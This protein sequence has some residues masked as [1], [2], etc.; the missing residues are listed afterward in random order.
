MLIR[1][2]KNPIRT[3][4]ELTESEKEAFRLKVRLW[5]YEEAVRTALFLLDDERKNGK[6][7]DPKRALSALEHALEPK[8]HLADDY[9]RE[10][11][12]GF[13]CGDCTCVAMSCSR[14]HAESIL[15]VDTLEGLGKHAARKIDGAFGENSE[16][17]IDEALESLSDYQPTRSG[18]WLDLP[19]AEFEKHVP[20]WQQEAK[21]AHGWLLNYKRE[22]GTS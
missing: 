1:W 19:E 13:H 7:Y 22:K 10:L 17:S 4:I 21:A 5:E 14:C 2:H 18:A 3:T 9:L 6:F 12:S 20:R 8:E 16:K 15:G 11:E